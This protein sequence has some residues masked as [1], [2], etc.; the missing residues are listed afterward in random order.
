VEQRKPVPEN[1]MLA[2]VL[3]TGASLRRFSEQPGAASHF[4][5]GAAE[6]NPEERIKLIR[7]YER[8]RKLPMNWM[9][10]SKLWTRGLSNLNASYQIATTIQVIYCHKIMNE[11]SAPA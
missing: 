6:M 10:K 7:E 2:F 8:L 11:V 3:F 5:F 9:F 1:G 4:L